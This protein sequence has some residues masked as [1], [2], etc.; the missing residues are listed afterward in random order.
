MRIRLLGPLEVL[1]DD[2][3]PAELPGRHLPRLLAVLAWQLN[4][5]V[6]VDTLQEALWG[7]LP[8]PAARS[9]L[10]VHVHHLRQAIGH[11]RIRLT[12]GGYA[13]RIEPGEL[14]VDE[15]RALAAAGSRALAAGRAAD[16]V[17]LLR[18]AVA[19]W[20]GTALEGL[21]D[22][23]PLDAAAD[24]LEELRLETV[25]QCVDAELGLG[26]SGQLVAELRALIA[27]HPFRE[28]PRGQL[29]MALHRSGRQA[30]AL[31]EYRRAGAVLRDEL[32]IEP[33]GAL[34][35]LHEQILTG[36]LPGPQPPEPPATVAP[37]PPQQQPATAL[38]SR[39][40]GPVRCLPRT[41]ADFTG[42]ESTIRALLK[43]IGERGEPGESA[44]VVV[45]VDGMAGSGKTTLAL[46]VAS[47]VGDRY[48][49]AHLYVNLHGH[50][51]Q[52]PLAPG[53][54]LM[55]L[56][57][58]LG[59]PAEAIPADA[60]ER[61]GLWRSEVAKRRVLVMLDN[62]AS[63]A[64][65]ADL[66]PAAASALTLVTGRRRLTR[67]EGV[68][69]ESLPV[70]DADEALTLL[71]SIVGDRVYAEAQA[72]Q[73]VVR[74]CGG[75]PLA[76][77]LAGARLAHRPRW[78][79]A[80]LV[81]RL[82]GSVLPQLAAEDRTVADAFVLSYRQLPQRAQWAFRLLGLHPAETFD[83]LAVAALA[84]LPLG[85]AE[86][87]LDEL[88]DVHLVEELDTGVFRLHDLIRE[89]AAMLVADLPA[90]DRRAAL[91]GLLDQ[92]MHA[93]AA[94]VE[95]ARRALL[96][97][98]LRAP[99]PLRPDLLAA[100]ADPAARLERERPHL[101]ALVRAAEAVEPAYAWRIPRA[102]WRYLWS[103]GYV[104]D[105]AS[106]HQRALAAAEL[107]GD[108]SAAA[109]VL[110]YLASAHYMRAELDQ[111]CEMMLRAVRLRERLGETAG[112]TSSLG[113]L[114]NIYGVMD[115][116]PDSMR[117]ALAAEARPVKSAGPSTAVYTLA[118]ASF[119]LGR[120]PD[121]LRYQRRALMA[122]A[123]A[124]DEARVGNCLLMLALI[125]H[126][127]GLA[128]T[129]RT[130]RL[131]TA[132]LRLFQRVH[133]RAG[134]IEAR[135]ELANLLRTQHRYAEALAEHRWVL[136]AIVP[137]RHPWWEARFR[138]DFAD[139]LRLAGR[140]GEARAMAEHALRIARGRR[141]SYLTARAQAGLAECLLTTDPAESRRLWEEARDTFARLGAIEV[142]DVDK[143][144]AATGQL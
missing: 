40:S 111:A 38:A 3:T 45:V 130:R 44:P 86:E 99:A 63:S 98:D 58:Q 37:P 117:V 129:G 6:S 120:Y 125:K 95:A 87:V 116:W 35:R 16:G 53:S 89:Y 141:L 34:Q 142:V 101:M 138:T 112:V 94:T 135:H 81:R 42:R 25:E 69:L 30:D 107:L 72:A 113:N 32:G 106:L 132:S 128:G 33:G 133:D 1:A 75:L 85:Q 144:L 118:Q 70:L 9:S 91:L 22:V 8:P 66:L 136:D 123:E 31:A 74:R 27:R 43:L 57:R 124:G 92:Q 46:H 54:A 47:L 100:L 39:A 51:E 59:I 131:L 10:R 61:V 55:I 83:A 104:D 122:A 102:A 97:R 29:M 121:A 60:V 137:I 12:G 24:E 21:R 19:L 143:R 110:H 140:A 13:L 23:L 14:D 68:H 82:D 88:V 114:A 17:A 108:D 90:A 7:A 126:A 76:V 103:R 67:L 20:R 50:S 36:T 84:G 109:T 5:P 139:T 93:A 64:Q 4:R 62:A 115:R 134:E 96:V 73:D 119:R 52:Q 49:D 41:V 80:E 28:R 105:I 71:A 2:G 15:F 65:V 11:S 18:S 77:R 127:A 78:R 48:P 79:V 26:S 56:L